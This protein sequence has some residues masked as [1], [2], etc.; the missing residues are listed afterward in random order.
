VPI[1]IKGDKDFVVE[2][3]IPLKVLDLKPSVGL[4][5]KG[6]WGILTSEDGHQVKT[7]AYWSNLNATGTAD[8]PTE[9]RLEPHRWGTI[10][11][12]TDATRRAWDPDFLDG[13][14]GANMKN[15]LDELEER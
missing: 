2:A 4:R 13:K 11:F 8:E 14:P 7:R 9:A 1:A 3:A 6:D 5:L 12:E 15:P 10:L